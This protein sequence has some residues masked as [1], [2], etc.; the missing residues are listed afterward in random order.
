MLLEKS[1]FEEANVDPIQ[2]LIDDIANKGFGVIQ[3]FLNLTETLSLKNIANNAYENEVMRPAGIGKDDNYRVVEKIRGDYIKWIDK[4][5]AFPET[6]NFLDKINN[7]KTELK[8]GL[9]LGIQD[10]ECHFAIYPSGSFY[11][12]HLDQHQHTKTRVLT[13]VCYLNESWLPDYG[14]AFRA[15]HEIGNEEL[16]TDIYPECG[17]LV[18]FRSDIIEHEV[19]PVFTERYSI[20]G[21][22]LDSLIL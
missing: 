5:S 20:T 14:G 8:R 9:Y 16:Y 22:M 15:Y 6:Q 17:K 3:N 11:K 21:W 18:C 10:I 2:Q 12:K 4:K 13:F 7:L 1:A 19:M